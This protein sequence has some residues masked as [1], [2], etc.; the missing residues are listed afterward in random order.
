VPLP[1]GEPLRCAEH[2]SGP[3]RRPNSKL[4]GI[5]SSSSGEVE[6]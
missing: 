4:S 6:P 3:Q 2:G 5:I 1:H